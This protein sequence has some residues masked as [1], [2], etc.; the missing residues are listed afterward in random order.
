MKDRMR[1]RDLITSVKALDE[2]HRDYIL[3][4]IQE[5]SKLEYHYCHRFWLT[6]SLTELDNEIS[7]GIEYKIDRIVKSV[8]HQST[9]IDS[10]LHEFKI[11]SDSKTLDN[12]DMDDAYEHLLKQVQKNITILQNE[13]EDIDNA[14]KLEKDFI[15]TEFKEHL[16]KKKLQNI[17]DD[18][19]R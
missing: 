5:N 14:I 6:L 10:F 15:K 12:K 7:S 1:A 2:E 11:Y 8:H 18:E 4:Y 13:K 17:I 16:R 9:L 3:E 19:T